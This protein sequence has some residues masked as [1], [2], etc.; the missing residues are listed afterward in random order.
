MS[1][2]R[3]NT[4]KNAFSEALL[5]EQNNFVEERCEVRASSFEPLVKLEVRD[6]FSKKK[7]NRRVQ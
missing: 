6:G 4:L 2:K 1:H 3:S 7:A 5:K